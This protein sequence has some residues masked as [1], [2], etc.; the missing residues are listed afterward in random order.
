MVL[1]LIMSGVAAVVVVFVLAAGVDGGGDV[2]AA[3]AVAGAGA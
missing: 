3:D 1:V 2:D